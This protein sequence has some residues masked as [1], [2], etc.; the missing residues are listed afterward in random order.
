[1]T[2]R[3]WLRCAWTW[4]LWRIMRPLVTRKR[5]SRKDSGRHGDSWVPEEDTP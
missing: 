5:Y 4:L 2:P 3:Q 1:M